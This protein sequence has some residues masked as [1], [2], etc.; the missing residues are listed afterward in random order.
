MASFL[1][2]VRVLLLSLLVSVVV[3]DGCEKPK[4]R[5]EW[6]KLSSDERSEWIKAV[7][8]LTTLPHDTNLAPIVPPNESLIPPIDK[9]TTFYDDLVYMHMDLNRRIH[10]TG[11]FLP[12][13][14]Y[15]VQYF[16]DVLTGKCGYKGVMPYWDWTQDAHDFYN[17]PFFD[18]SSSG[19]GGWGDPDNDFQIKDGGFK[20]MVL[21][22]PSPHHIRRNFSLFPFTNPSLIP[23]WGND[24]AAPPRPVGFMVNTT[25]TKQNVDFVVNGFEGNYTSMHAYLDSTNGTHINIHLIMGADLTGL[26]PKAAVG[27][28]S[29]AKWTPNDPLFF[30]H[31]AM[32]D[33]IW[34]DWQHKSPKNK[35]VFAGGSVAALDSFANFVRFPN[36]LPPALGFDSELPGDGLWKDVKVSDVMDTVAGKLC[37]VYE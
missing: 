23:P 9:D 18:P 17:S 36:G 12:W 27:C 15:Y 28:V 21:A 10:F 6:R 24:P 31:H 11:L 1:G 26:C 35:D 8:C 37:Y 7:N 3:A 19:V 29:G 32:V 2:L 34:Y 14:R 13:H 20:D 22:Y 25:M 5:R 4:V 16:E 33:K 30:M